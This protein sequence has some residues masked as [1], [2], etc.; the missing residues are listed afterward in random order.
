MSVS[1][2][3]DQLRPI[4]ADD[5]EDWVSAHRALR[6]K[7]T[8]RE[9]ACECWTGLDSDLGTCVSKYSWDA[10]SSE[11]NTSMV[12]SEQFVCLFRL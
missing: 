8:E 7:Q 2:L 3:L 4:F 1:S 11:E 6:N 10:S 5:T 9:V 12:A